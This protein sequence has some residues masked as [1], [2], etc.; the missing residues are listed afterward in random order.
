MK[1]IICDNYI[2]LRNQGGG[3]GGAND[4]N[5]MDYLFNDE[6]ETEVVAS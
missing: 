1:F 6:D 3:A 5:L 4:M 2:L